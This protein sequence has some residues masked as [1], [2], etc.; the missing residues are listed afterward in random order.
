MEGQL[1]DTTGQPITGARVEA[2]HANTK[3]FHSHCKVAVQLATDDQ[4]RC[5][6]PPPFPRHLALGLWLPPD[7]STQKLLGL[8]GRHGQ[9]PAHIHFFVY[10]PGYRHLTTQ[11]N[12]AGEKYVYDDFAF[13]TCEGPVVEAV[14]RND[15]KKIKE[16]GVDGPYSEIRFDFT[17]NREAKAD[18][19]CGA[20]PLSGEVTPADW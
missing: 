15:P 9:R 12:L 3:G 18:H 10:A 5:R 8:L 17:L 7:G 13:A 11:I 4:G 1:K 19:H 6:G 20:R 16:R 2:W 14:R